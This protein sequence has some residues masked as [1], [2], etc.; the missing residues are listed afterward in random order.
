MQLNIIDLR[1]T[2]ANLLGSLNGAGP[3]KNNENY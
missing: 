2:R 3:E 1:V